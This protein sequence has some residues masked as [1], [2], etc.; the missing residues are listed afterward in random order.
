MPLGWNINLWISVVNVRFVKITG[1]WCLWNLETLMWLKI[2]PVRE[3]QMCMKIEFE[4]EYPW[5]LFLLGHWYWKYKFFHSNPLFSSSPGF[6]AI[7]HLPSGDENIFVDYPPLSY[8]KSCVL[9]CSYLS[10]LWSKS[11][12]TCK[13]SWFQQYCQILPVFELLFH[14]L[15]RWDQK[16]S[17][18]LQSTCQD[19]TFDVWQRVV[20]S[21]M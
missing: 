1:G 8:I 20:D 2:S 13:M 12:K 11:W 15:L 3:S 17:S 14:I 5:K 18:Y 4:L 6:L 7:L 19:T 21:L 9:A 16:W 10:K